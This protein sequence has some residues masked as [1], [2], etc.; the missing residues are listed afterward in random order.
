MRSLIEHA[1][2]ELKASNLRKYSQYE[3][4]IL[5]IVEM[6]ENTDLED[7]DLYNVLDTIKK[8][9]GYEVLSPLTGEAEEWEKIEDNLYINKRYP[10]V[11][12]KTGTPDGEA[13]DELRIVY[14]PAIFRYDETNEG[15]ITFKPKPVSIEFPYKPRPHTL[16]YRY[17][18]I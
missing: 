7:R 9:L 10:T 14:K 17:A 16:T 4:D 3:D 8:L 12:S 11:H 5:G 13:W 1:V 6:F 15:T 18:R 2:R